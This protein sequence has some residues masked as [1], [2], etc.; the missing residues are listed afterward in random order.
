MALLRYLNTQGVIELLK[1]S[2][3][4]FLHS[5]K[6][7]MACSFFSDRAYFLFLYKGW[8]TVVLYFYFPQSMPAECEATGLRVLIQQQ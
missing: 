8:Y 5:N 7:K 4:I 2:E 3:S 1:Y 6:K